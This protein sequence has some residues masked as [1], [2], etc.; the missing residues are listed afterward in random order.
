MSSPSDRRQAIAAALAWCPY[1][2][3]GYSDP[4]IH[5]PP[6]RDPCRNGAVLP[7]YKL[8]RHNRKKGKR[9]K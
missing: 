5:Y 1:T 6:R 8:R 4:P 3:M 2:S 9:G 7:D